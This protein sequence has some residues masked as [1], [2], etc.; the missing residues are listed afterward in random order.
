MNWSSRHLPLSHQKQ[1]PIVVVTPIVTTTVPVSV[2]PPSVTQPTLPPVPA[3]LTLYDGFQKWLDDQKVKFDQRKISDH[4]YYGCVD[5]ID[6]VKQHLPDR[7]LD[8]LTTLDIQHMIGTFT[9]RPILKTK[10]T[11]MST[12]YAY[13][14]AMS[15]GCALRFLDSKNIWIAPRNLRQALKIEFAAP[16]NS[17]LKAAQKPKPCF[18]LDELKI[19]A[20]TANP[21][22][23]KYLLCGLFLGWTQAEMAVALKEDVVEKDGDTFVWRFRN[24]TG[25]EGKWWCCA[26]LAQ[27]L[28][29]YVANTDDNNQGE[30]KKALLFLTEQGKP[31][32]WRHT[33]LDGKRQ[34]RACRV[35]SVGQVWK[36]LQANLKNIEDIR[37]FP[38]KVLRKTGA[39]M[40]EAL[41]SKD[42]AQTF[43]A[44]SKND[45]ASDHYLAS[46]TN[47]G[48]GTSQF[49]RLTCRDRTVHPTE[50]DRRS[51]LRRTSHATTTPRL[52]TT[53]NPIVE[54]ASPGNSR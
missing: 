25:V 44:H 26:E 15:V 54:S 18:T 32:L 24:K 49:E 36:R 12:D 19:L 43:L 42:V 28:R 46:G 47:V 8:C 51:E 20:R 3:G 2:A 31:L 17:Q 53:A 1:A 37:P 52:N 45:V 34:G 50:H 21:L 5:A 29:W 27:T 22:Q 30:E 33:T 6:V 11:P 13:R 4:H 16:T 10:G 7:P 41:S 23:W 38:L 40:V 48:V 14:M 9:C 35:D 39:T